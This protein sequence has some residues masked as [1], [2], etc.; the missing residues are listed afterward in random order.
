M[1]LQTCSRAS[2]VPPSLC[3]KTLLELFASR[4]DLHEEAALPPPTGTA[5]PFSGTTPMAF[6]PCSLPQFSSW[7]PSWLPPHWGALTP[8]PSIALCWALLCWCWHQKG[9]TAWKTCPLASGS[10]CPCHG[11]ISSPPLSSCCRSK[12]DPH[13][14]PLFPAACLPYCRTQAAPSLYSALRTPK[15]EAD[16]CQNDPNQ[17][18]KSSSQKPLQNPREIAREAFHEPEH[19]LKWKLHFICSS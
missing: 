8:L 4:P 2:A 5:C 3:W 9:L 19:A 14:F 17:C 18:N 1:Q 11:S 12:A 6:F 15:T 16:S 13:C 7:E 10:P